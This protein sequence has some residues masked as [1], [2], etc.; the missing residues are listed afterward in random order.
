MKNN[1]DYYQH[2]PGQPFLTWRQFQWLASLFYLLLLIL[3]LLPKSTSAANLPSLNQVSLQLPWSHQFQFAG[4]YAALENGYYKEEGLNV[5][6]KEWQP[7]INPT[8]EVIKGHVN[9]GIGRADLL[10]SRLHG[11]PI[12]VLAAIFQHSPGIL[13]VKKESNISSPQDMVGKRVMWLKGEGSAEFEAMFR[14]EGIPIEQIKKIPASYNINDLIDG[15][16][17]VFYAY[18]TNEPFL[19]EQQNVESLSI[20]PRTYGIDFYGDCLF[21]SRQEQQSNPE[22][23]RAFRAASLKGWE[24]AMQHPEETIDLLL[25]KY[26]VKKTRKHLTFEAIAI[27]HLMLPDLVSIGH[28]NRGRFQHMADTY[29]SLGM[30]KSAKFKNEF[31]YNPDIS[32]DSLRNRMVFRVTLIALTLILG[33]ACFLWVLNHKLKSM[34]NERTATLSQANKELEDEVTQRQ[35]AE[36]NLKMFQKNLEKIVKEKTIS[37]EKEKQN[38]EAANRA[39]SE[40]LANMSHEIRTPMNAIIGMT[41]LVLETPLNKQQQHYIET[42]EGAADGLLALLNDILDFSKIE[43]GQLALEKGAA[44]LADVLKKGNRTLRLTAY[45]KNIDFFCWLDFTL[46]TKIICDE[47]RIRQIFSNL[48]SNSIKFTSKGYVLLTALVTEET[49][50]TITISFSVRDTGVGIPPEQQKVIFNS[51]SQADTSIA[52]KYGGSGLGLAIAKNL[53]EM[54]GGELTVTS[55]EQEG[56]TFSFTLDFQKAQPLPTV[57][58]FTKKETSLPILLIHPSEIYRQLL[59]QH[60]ES[61]G[62]SVCPVD[63]TKDGLKIL[64]QYH[65]D[66]KQFG[67]IITEHQK[68][69]SEH[70]V[71]FDT[72]A[73]YGMATKV[74]PMQ[75]AKNLKLCD[76]CINFPISSCLLH[77]FSNHQFHTAVIDGFH[78]Y[79]CPGAQVI[80]RRSTRADTN[81]I[82]SQSILLVEDNMVNQELAQIL[83]EQQGHTVCLADNG[84]LAL[85]Q[86]QK[87]EPFDLIFMDVQ[88]P[89]MDGLAT[90]R[91]IRACEAG[92][93]PEE[94]IEISLLQALQEKLGG[95]HIPIIA[96]T[97]NALAGDHERCLAAGMDEYITKPYKQD[98]IVQIIQEIVGATRKRLFD[99]AINHLQTEYHL[100]S[101]QIEQLLQVSISSIEES[102]LAAEQAL[103]NLNYSDL[104]KAMHKIKG[105]LSSL[106]LSAAVEL[107]QEI[108]HDLRLDVDKDY[109]LIFDNLRNSIQPLIMK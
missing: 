32:P 107:A 83:L 24:Y 89:V 52:R 67:L 62:F 85:R 96:M 46:S 106:G 18:S 3:I 44:S 47:L 40:F 84:L 94:K 55:K 19:L 20:T 8:T 61:F 69:P 60:L 23:V 79:K 93:P 28:M 5:T 77:P 65:K 38:A 30:A 57:D 39:K 36:I 73:Q 82:A 81:L 59:Q 11:Q 49:A 99:Q 70:Y 22:R 95:Q 97:A 66:G 6:I 45:D 78:G 34:I 68:D 109:H 102:L 92:V 13:L 16:T 104:Q 29:V 21:T 72:L 75:H 51:F 105:T 25:A 101:A 12:V 88:M 48:I 10:L 41:S 76:D 15:K 87:K 7:G 103:Q 35:L 63:H 17:D 37:L 54:M 1:L 86:L 27:R 42:V 80:S 26:H 4:Y 56:S 100:K 91:V 108:E 74:I 71:L 98:E 64:H 90:T 50:E 33:V 2:N 31:I 9:F 14:N 43:A 58:T 53:V